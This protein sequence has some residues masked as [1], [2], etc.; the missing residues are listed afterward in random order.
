MA[1]IAA[2]ERKSRAKSRVADGV[3]G[4]GGGAV[5]AEGFGGHVAVDGEAGA[6]QGGAAEGAFVHAGAGVAQAGAVAGQHLDIGEHVMTEGDGLRRLEVGEAGHGVGGEFGGAVGE[7]AHDVG[8]LGIKAVDGVADPEAE[9]GGDLVVAAAPG[10]QAFAGFADAV[11]EAGL[12]VH[13]DVFK[14]VDEREAAGFDLGGD[15]VEALVDGVGVGALDDADM[16]EHG[17]VSAAAGDVLA[18]QLAIEA[19]RG[20]YVLHDDGGSAGEAAA[21]LCVGVD[22]APLFYLEGQAR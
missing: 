3:E 8:D 19:D 21:P 12:D 5:E 18:P 17:G 1:E 13:V 15:L 10:V 4:V 16:G 9:I 6:G 20:I 14:V 7:G 22:V 2:A 11:G